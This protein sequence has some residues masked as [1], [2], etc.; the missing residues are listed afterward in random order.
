MRVCVCVGGGGL[1]VTNTEYGWAMD[2]SCQC[3]VVLCSIRG[4]TAVLPIRQATRLLQA[5]SQATRWVVWNS[6]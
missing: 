3:A 5:V 6:I 1:T 2:L 4:T